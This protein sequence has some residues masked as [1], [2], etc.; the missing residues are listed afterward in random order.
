[1]NVMPLLDVLTT[2]GIQP[3]DD[4]LLHSSFRAVKKLLGVNS[5]DKEQ[6][7]ICARNFLLALAER[8]S[9]AN[10]LIPTE[11]MSDYNL[12]SFHKEILDSNSTSNRGYLTNAFLT[13]SDN[14]KRSF[15]PIYNVS[16]LGDGYDKEI[17][18]HHNHLFTMEEG[19]PWHKFTVNKGKI[20]FLGVG[21]HSNSLIH[22]PEYELGLEY[23]RPVFMHKPHDFKVK[24]QNGIYDIKGF[25]HGI[26][27]EHDTVEKFVSYMAEKYN[28][29]SK[30]T[31]CGVEI[32]VIDAETQ[33][34]GLH[35]EL[36]KG[37]SWY[38]AMAW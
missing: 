37:I 15:N 32:I 17:A 25:V 13:L 27:W 24:H 36:K 16:I 9:N 34:L 11:F 30:A 3:N 10:I 29:V 8:H 7:R 21:V 28:H 22:I 23:P 31:V 5:S 18:N 12:Q 2:L 6:S 19:T 35:E 33:W 20:I 26:K 14:I 1:M 38:D 4:I